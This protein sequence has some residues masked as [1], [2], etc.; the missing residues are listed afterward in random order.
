M[1]IGKM[2]MKMGM[3][4]PRQ[5]LGSHGGILTYVP[6]LASLPCVQRPLN[7]AAAGMAG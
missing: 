3:K 6:C 1:A 7:H 5:T 2:K 4:M